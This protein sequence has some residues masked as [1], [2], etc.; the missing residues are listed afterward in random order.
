M[1][2]SVFLS[3]LQFIH[4]VFLCNFFFGK[5]SKLV[6]KRSKLVFQVKGTCPHLLKRIRFTWQPKRPTTL[7]FSCFMSVQPFE[8]GLHYMSL[9]TRSTRILHRH[10]LTGKF[11]CLCIAFIPRC[12][13][14]LKFCLRWCGK[15]NKYT[16]IQTYIQ[17]PTLFSYNNFNKP[18][19]PTANRSTR[20]V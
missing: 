12:Y 7:F 8:K 5:W 18:G 10:V 4:A 13:W 11:T 2:R 17:T 15:T 20:L 6:L 9:Q 3:V 1:H 14:F 19:M 16:Y